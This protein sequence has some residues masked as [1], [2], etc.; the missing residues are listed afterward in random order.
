MSKSWAYKWQR[1]RKGK[2]VQFQILQFN[3][4]NQLLLL[5]S[6]MY[7]WASSSSSTERSLK[8]LTNIS[9]SYAGHFTCLAIRSP[10]L[11][12]FGWRA[13][14]ERGDPEKDIT[15]LNKP[16][17]TE[18]IF[19]LH[20]SFGPTALLKLSSSLPFDKGESMWSI[21][22]MPPAQSPPSVTRL[23]F[24]PN[25]AMFWLIHVRA[26]TWSNKP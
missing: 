12:C 7:F 14:W 1:F 15:R 25:F 9:W 11:L 26:E 6:N 5:T 16:A 20:N 8:H 19:I 23:G 4:L 13:Q 2:N 3:K 10:N 17:K 18:H 21:D 24:P 22:D